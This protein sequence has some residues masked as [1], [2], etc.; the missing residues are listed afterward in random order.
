MRVQK[1]ARFAARFAAGGE[2]MPYVVLS[3]GP[4]C[5]AVSCL[6]ARRLNALTPSAARP[7]CAPVLA[8]ALLQG[9][10]S[11]AAG[12]LSALATC[13]GAAAAPCDAPPPPS[14]ASAVGNRTAA[15]MQQQAASGAAAGAAATATTA[16]PLERLAERL[17][18][19]RRASG[20]NGSA[21]P[22]PQR[23]AEW[24]AAGRQQQQPE[25]TQGAGAGGGADVWRL[26]G[27]GAVASALTLGGSSPGAGA[28]NAT[29][30]AAWPAFCACGR[31]YGPVCRER[32]LRWFPSAC[33][34]KCQVRGGGRACG[35]QLQCSGL[36][37]SHTAGTHTSCP[38]RAGCG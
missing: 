22:L 1:E 15:R 16:T 18:V 34:A 27:G 33:Y 8:V 26:A 25:Q 5:E 21:G 29:T 20:G 3:A 2:S 14:V 32:D 35:G 36:S 7:S 30:A 28:A 10:G 9:L 24:R 19:L 6:L 31:E 13:P 17:A 11:G 23:L 37:C 38:S 4:S 12:V